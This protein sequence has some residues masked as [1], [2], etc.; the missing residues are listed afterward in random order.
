MTLQERRAAS[1]KPETSA[2]FGTIA[3]ALAQSGAIYMNTLGQVSWSVGQNVSDKKST[4]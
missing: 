2:S 1:D 4:K 3:S